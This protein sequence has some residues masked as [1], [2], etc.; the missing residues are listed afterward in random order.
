MGLVLVAA[1]SA[2]TGAAGNQDGTDPVPSAS[3]DGGVQSA[4]QF[5]RFEAGLSDLGLTYSAKTDAAAEMIGGLKGQKYTM[6]G[7]TIEL[8]QF[9]P[10][11]DAYKAAEEKQ[12]VT[13]EGFG[14]FAVYVHNGM[15]MMK[16]GVPQSVV[17]LFNTL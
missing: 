2:C 4:D 6:D 3:Q 7:Y 9:D 17:D 8:Y 14:D 10:E 5:A 16:D 13:L 15:V 1:L 12:A 11:S